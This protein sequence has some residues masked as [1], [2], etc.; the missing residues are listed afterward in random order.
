M[1]E[2]GRLEKLKSYAKKR[3][4]KSFKEAEHGD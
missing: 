3:Y 2:D 1:I 4:L